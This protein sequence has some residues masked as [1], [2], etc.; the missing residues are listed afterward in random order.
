M[1]DARPHQDPS[2]VR[3]A[4]RDLTAEERERLVEALA[5]A[6]LESVRERRRRDAMRRLGR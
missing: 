6:V 1:S 3:G 5:Q 4:I 2:A